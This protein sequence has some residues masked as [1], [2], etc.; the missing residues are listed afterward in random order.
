MSLTDNLHKYQQPFQ[1]MRTW[2]EEFWE[3]QQH[4]HFTIHGVRHSSSTKQI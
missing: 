1:H 4:T 3:H 2:C